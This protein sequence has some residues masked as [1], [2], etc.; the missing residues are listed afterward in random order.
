MNANQ[1][2]SEA[3]PKGA[4][5]GSL[6]LVT[7]HPPSVT[8]VRL[9]GDDLLSIVQRRSATQPDSDD[10]QLLDPDHNS[11]DNQVQAV[12]VDS[13]AGDHVRSDSQRS[14]VPGAPSSQPSIKIVT[15]PNGAPSS[16]WL[17]LRIWAEML[18]DA[19]QA[20]IAATNR[21]ERGGVDPALYTAHLDTLNIAEHQCLLALRR[22]YRRVTPAGIIGWQKANNG[23]GIDRL[24]RLLGHL[25]HPRIATPHHWEGTGS[26]RTLIADEPFERSVSQL[27]QY[28]GV[29]RPERKRKGMSADE[30]AAQGNPV[31]K[32]Q[33]WL[34]SV[35]CMKCMTS[36]YRAVYDDAREAYADKMHSVECVRC[37]PSGKPAQVGSSWSAGH[38]HAAA[39]RKTGKEILRDLWQVSA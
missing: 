26:A 20:R 39:L 24:A 25:G 11:T 27:W 9:V 16:G 29:G 18:H 2:S 21:A 8:N 5:P 15:L 4:T 22:C 32:S 34:A 12:G 30:L 35:E 23:I 7:D 28:C 19:Q 33:I 3:A 14:N 6:T 13:L 31:L 10:A 37:G 38:Q 36:P 1:A 17:E